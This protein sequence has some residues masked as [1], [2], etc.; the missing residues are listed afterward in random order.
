MDCTSPVKTTKHAT[1]ARKADPRYHPHHRSPCR[2][3]SHH[4]LSSFQREV[5]V[6][7]VRVRAT[8]V[9]R[10]RMTLTLGS[11]W[12]HDRASREEKPS[13]QRPA[14]ARRW[15]SLFQMT[16]IRQ[17]ESLAGH[18]RLLHHHNGC[19]DGHSNI[20]HAENP[21]SWLSGQT[22]GCL[23]DAPLLFLPLMCYRCFLNRNCTHVPRIENKVRAEWRMMRVTWMIEDGM[24]SSSWIARLVA[25]IVD[26]G[27]RSA[28]SPL[29][30]LWT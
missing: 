8:V 4:M 18:Q 26:V 2:S 27:A 28:M 14:K 12:H 13:E 20:R 3:S 7:I 16:K 29:L 19:V 15:G 23:R 5:V 10:T 6:S 22:S 21:Q 30:C 25:D 9:K 17:I 24:C 11:C 1:A